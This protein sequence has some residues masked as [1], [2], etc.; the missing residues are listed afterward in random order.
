MVNQNRPLPSGKLARTVVVTVAAPL[1]PGA[2]GWQKKA[3]APDKAGG[4]A[5]GGDIGT[6]SLRPD[7]CGCQTAEETDPRASSGGWARGGQA[8]GFGGF[9]CAAGLVPVGEG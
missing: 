7:P 3:D 2:G 8:C 6:R 1:R 4:L 9:P 5:G